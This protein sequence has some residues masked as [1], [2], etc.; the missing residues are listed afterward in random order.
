M[1]LNAGFDAEEAQRMALWCWMPDQVEEFDAAH[2]AEPHLTL[3]DACDRGM[4]NFARGELSQA[5][6]GGIRARKYSDTDQYIRVIHRGLHVLT[7]G[8]AFAETKKRKEIIE[9]LPASTPLLFRGLAFHAFGDCFAHRQL[10]IGASGIAGKFITEG[11]DTMYGSRGSDGVLARLGHARDGHDID[12]IFH[13]ARGLVYVAYVRALDELANK[14]KNKQAGQGT[15]GI[16]D[17]IAALSAMV[18]GVPNYTDGHKAFG[19]SW[20]TIKSEAKDLAKRPLPTAEGE[21]CTHIKRVAS[22]LVKIK[23]DETLDPNEEPVPW[24]EY[25]RRNSYKSWLIQDSGGEHDLGQ[26]LYN[27]QKRIIEW[28]GEAL[29]PQR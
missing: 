7:G 27:I 19:F 22:D 1:F 23:M 2:V 14:L 5:K 11:S 9:T 20:D 21:C 12:H 6:N 10:S 16:N 25:C 29:P 13:P 4:D 28:S 17:M 26:I 3:L 18:Q 24:T 15:I 8:A